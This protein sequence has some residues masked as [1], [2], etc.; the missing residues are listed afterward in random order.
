MKYN[1]IGEQLIAKAQEL[2]PNYKPDKFN[3]MSEALDVILNNSGGG[4]DEY[5]DLVLSYQQFMDYLNDYNLTIPT[6]IITEE[7]IWPI[8]LGK[9]K[10]LLLKIQS[11]ADGDM[12]EL[13]Y[14]TIPFYLDMTSERFFTNVISIMGQIGYWTYLPDFDQENQIFTF[15]SIKGKVMYTPTVADGKITEEDWNAI[16]AL[17]ENDQLLGVIADGINFYLTY[18]FGSN[19]N[20]QYMFSAISGNTGFMIGLSKNL[21]FQTMDCTYF[22]FQPNQRNYIPYCGTSY[23]DTIALKIGSGLQVSNENNLEV[24]GIYY[25]LTSVNDKVTDIQYNEITKLMNNNSLAGVKTAL[26]VFNFSNA[27]ESEIIFHAIILSETTINSTKYPTIDDIKLII[28][29]DRSLKTVWYTKPVIEFTKKND[30]YNNTYLEFKK[31]TDTQSLYKIPELP[32]D[33]STKTYVLKSVN[34]VL[35]WSE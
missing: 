32:S 18:V 2:D 4:D 16:N 30:S 28:K 27:N 25:D 12:P 24:N 3:D 14:L 35:T 33:A 26:G 34:G 20:K 19:N 6:N 13:F 23:E 8:A 1:S 22:T 11:P 10:G 9:K 17:S 21:E 5:V 7:I 29:N 15:N 31:E